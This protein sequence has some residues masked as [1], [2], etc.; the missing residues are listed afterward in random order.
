MRNG[1]IRRNRHLWIAAS[2][3]LDRM[4]THEDQMDIKPPFDDVQLTMLHACYGKA[5]LS[6]HMLEMRLSLFMECHAVEHGYR[7]SPEAIKRM[8][9]GMLVNE[10][11]EKH[12]PPD[13]LAEELDNMVFFRN[14]LAHRISSMIFSRAAD[15]DWHDK[16]IQ[17][18]IDIDSFFKETIALLNPYMENCYRV[19]GVTN[20]QLHSIAGRVYPGLSAAIKSAPDVGQSEISTQAEHSIDG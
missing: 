8:T 18:L 1:K 5:V 13:S 4:G 20:S 10:F 14:D 7:A 11:I 15:A 2:G 6:A 9:L 3:A 12:D 17:E 16:I 19:L